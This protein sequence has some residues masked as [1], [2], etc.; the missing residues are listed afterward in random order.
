MNICRSL[1]ARCETLAE[2]LNLDT[3]AAISSYA[4]AKERLPEGATSP[5]VEEVEEQVPERWSRLKGER[6]ALLDI[7]NG[8]VIREHFGQ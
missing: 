6:A 1:R 5:S 4:M 2:V 7:S 8:N 3:N